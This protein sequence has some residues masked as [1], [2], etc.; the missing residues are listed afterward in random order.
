MEHAIQEK[1]L[2]PSAVAERVCEK[3][4]GQDEG[5]RKMVSAFMLMR[6]RCMMLRR[7]T[8]SDDLP[9]I[10]GM[11]IMGSTASG[12][13]F[14]IKTLLKDV[15]MQWFM[16][17]CASLTGEGWKGDS[18]S[19]VLLLVAEW[20]EEHPGELCA[21]VWDEFDKIVRKCSDG[22][23]SFSAMSA[24]LK[25]LDGGIQEIAGDSALRGQ[26]SVDMD[27]VINI[28]AGAFTGIEEIVRKRLISELGGTTVGFSSLPGD[29]A[30]EL[31]NANTEELR[32]RT[33]V[34]DLVEW[35]FPWELC[36]RISVIV[37]FKA[38][39]PQTLEDIVRGP[40]LQHYRNITP[41]GCE[42]SLSDEAIDYAVDYAV[43]S[44]LGARGIDASLGA[45]VIDAISAANDSEVVTG[46]S[47]CVRDNELDF[48][49]E[50]GVRP[51]KPQ[52]AV[53]EKGMTDR[54]F[55]RFLN[56]LFDGGFDA[57]MQAA[58]YYAELKTAIEPER[59]ARLT[60]LWNIDKACGVL[61]GNAGNVSG[62]DFISATFM[63]KAMMLFIIFRYGEGY[64][65]LGTVLELLPQAQSVTGV[66]GER[67][68]C[69]AHL[70]SK[71][72]NDGEKGTYGEALRK[73]GKL[74]E[75]G[76]G[77]FDYISFYL[78][79]LAPEKIPDERKI[80]RIAMRRLA[81]A[82][83]D[84]DELNALRKELNAV[85]NS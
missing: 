13:S 74:G 23:E 2:R 72:I 45:T 56:S 10:R 26:K 24:L 11:L 67:Q 80:A 63:L 17:N 51:E 70:I 36:G 64:A 1:D 75:D 35:G 50:I 46:I 41:Y 39:S 4:L 84:K 85:L 83:V 18:V 60:S 32:S 82:C 52:E 79:Q 76:L 5:C 62:S 54:E 48:G 55:E 81:K 22:D 61:I 49:L 27:G 20:Q 40:F 6:E 15:G 65:H 66:F 47:V 12:K 25:P 34:K 3:V 29:E 28:F 33:T 78:K 68:S 58:P 42:L 8:D 57:A 16:A 44:K 71:A 38:L 14:A 69:F 30:S 19:N 43:Q 9:N 59:F 7:G 53:E 21:I 37:P 77:H 31:R 73:S